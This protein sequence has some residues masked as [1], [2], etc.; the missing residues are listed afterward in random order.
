M[1]RPVESC[2]VR[3]CH[4]SHVNLKPSGLML[5]GFSIVVEKVAD[6]KDEAGTFAVSD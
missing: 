1:S 3:S 2:Q 5:D 6:P 4:G